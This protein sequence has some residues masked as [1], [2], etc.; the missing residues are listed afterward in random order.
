[1]ASIKFGEKV[2]FSVTPKII[3]DLEKML[4]EWVVEL[5]ENEGDIDLN[6]ASLSVAQKIVVM[7]SHG[8]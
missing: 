5:S 7:L 4:G 2:T 6:K 1:M 8:Q 3:L